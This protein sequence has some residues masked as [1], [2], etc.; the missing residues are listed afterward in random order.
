M[1]GMH[2]GGGGGGGGQGWMWAGDDNVLL[3]NL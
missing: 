3:V 2:G 1:C